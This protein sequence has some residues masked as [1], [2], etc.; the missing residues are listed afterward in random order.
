MNAERL[1][2]LAEHLKTVPRKH[3]SMGAWGKRGFEKHACG[4]TACA[5]GWAC[6]IKKFKQAG[7]KMHFAFKDAT[8]GYPLFTLKGE[9]GSAPIVR[10][11]SEAIS[12]F[13]E[14]TGHETEYLFGADHERTPKQEARAILNFVK[15]GTIPE[16]ARVEAEEEADF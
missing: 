7:L 1:T 12:Y 5:A 9:D 14:L 13:F 8:H 11:G 2:I 4:T 6:T 3:F 10:D 16:K 15:T